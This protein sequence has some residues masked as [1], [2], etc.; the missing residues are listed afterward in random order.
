MIIIIILVLWLSLKSLKTLGFCLYWLQIKEYRWDR[1]NLLIQTQP[2]QRAIGQHLSPAYLPRRPW[3][4]PKLTKRLILTLGLLI[5]IL[6]WLVYGLWQEL[7]WSWWLRIMVIGLGVNLSLPLVVVGV[8]LI[9]GLAAGLAK[10]RLINQAKQ[11]L[12]QYPDLVVIGITGSYAKTSTAH[13][14]AAILKTKYQVLVTPENQNT[15]I[16]VAQLIKQQLQPKHQILIVEMG[17]YKKGEIK[18]LCQLVKPKIGLVTAINLQ[19]L[20]LFKSLGNLL[21]AKYELI[22]AL[23]SDGLAIFNVNNQYTLA[24][25]KKT[26]K[27]KVKLFGQEKT[28]YPTGLVGDWQQQNIQA[29]LV[30]AEELQIAKAQALAAIK[31]LKSLPKQ[32]KI[33]KGLNGA[34]IIDDTYSANPTGFKVAL[35]LTEDYAGYSKLVLTPGIIELSYRSRL[36]HHDLAKAMLKFKI[37]ELILTQPDTESYFDSI[38]KTA[39]RPPQLKVKTNF[40]ELKSYLNSVL[41]NQSLILVEG[42]MPAGLIKFLK[43]K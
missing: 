35:K 17:A 43:G 27:V 30:V 14:L 32:L 23:P 41:D 25:A 24:M 8:N 38:F 39:K 21:T 1:V 6:G 4:R 31:E 15:L 37:K 18:R 3:L 40:K 11:K 42:R 16:A 12:N 34:I 29:A 13:I 9:V 2:F 20:G 7:S 19:H 10:R 33:F 28:N 36:V 22:Q 26:K 5:M